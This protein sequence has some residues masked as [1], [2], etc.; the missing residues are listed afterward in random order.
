MNFKLVSPDDKVVYFSG[1]F[2]P[3]SDLKTDQPKSTDSK[4]LLKWTEVQKAIQSGKLVDG[5]SLIFDK[6]IWAQQGG[7]DKYYYRLFQPNKTHLVPKAYRH[8]ARELKIVISVKTATGLTK[9]SS[10]VLPIRYQ[11]AFDEDSLGPVEKEHDGSWVMIK[12]KR[13]SSRVI[14]GLEYVSRPDILQPDSACRKTWDLKYNFAFIEQDMIFESVKAV[15]FRDDGKWTYIEPTKDYSG[16][17]LPEAAGKALGGGGAIFTPIA[18]YGG[19]CNYK[20]WG[21]ILANRFTETE[22]DGM[23]IDFLSKSNNWVRAVFGLTVMEAF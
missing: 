4:S 16:H 18:G 10:V 8:T 3:E 20:V 12:D 2:S 15:A 13:I 6:K 19:L 5:D 17:T 1:T 7:S 23:E 22:A 11:Y 14:G 21:V 9:T